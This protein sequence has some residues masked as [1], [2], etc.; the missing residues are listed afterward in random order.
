[1]LVAAT[2]TGC[3]DEAPTAGGGG[4]GAGGGG[5]MPCEP[6][7]A[8]ID[9]EC[10]AAGIPPE[11]CGAGF[12]PTAERG[13]RPVLPDEPCPKGLMAVPGETTCRPV[14]P[15]GTGPW[16]TI[17][18]EPDTQYVDGAYAGGDSDGTAD[19]PWTTIQ[20][21]VDAALPGAIVAVAAGSYEEWVDVT[22]GQV[23]LWGRC[24]ELVE[25]V[26]PPDLPS[27]SVMAGADGAE[28]RDL[29]VRGGGFGVGS[30]GA[31]DV[32]LDR[33][34]VHDVAGRGI[35]VAKFL[36]PSRVAIRRSLIEANRAQGVFAEGAEV[37]MEGVVIRDTEPDPNF[38]VGRGIYLTDHPDTS[39]PSRA[40]VTGSVVE[41]NLVAGLYVSGSELT[42]RSTAVRNT[43]P[44]DSGVGG[45]GIYAVSN[46]FTGL[47]SVLHVETS[48]VA[49]NHYG[50]VVAEGADATILTTVVRDTLPL[51]NGRWGWGI[52]L[53]AEPDTGER[54][55]ATVQATLVDGNHEVGL[56]V[57]GAT[58]ELER[59]IVEDTAP[60]RNDIAGRGVAIQIDL[61]TGELSQAQVRSS[62]IQRNHDIG[63]L[64]ADSD[65]V[66]EASVVSES[67]AR[68]SDG[69]FGDGIVAASLSVRSKAV[70]THS[71]VEQ[72]AR[73]GVV[74]F[75]SDFS[76]G[77]TEIR[78]APVALD[79][80]EYQGWSFAFIDLGGNDCSCADAGATC[81]VLS[82][83]LAPPEPLDG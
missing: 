10:L 74:S 4:A 82:D 57:G 83:G 12:Q 32:L 73:A 63:L 2:L 19:K 51:A 58:V 77:W 25:I 75:G 46:P 52:V 24:P 56:D 40:T 62:I 71:L 36:G 14:A 17:P 54:T 30:S 42:V 34:W 20:A 55:V 5:T 9:G 15:C 64:V 70:V 45:T 67:M 18:V 31:L 7:E 23:R 50:G 47:R 1:M 53:R 76:L 11:A 49:D 13:C 37:A 35:E 6:G 27:V 3:G 69:L 68:V 8:W 79:G 61:L 44:H 39:Q 38:G 78:C 48:V 80:E 33:L 29:A 28:V 21:G 81:K 41:R 59:L 60:G 66:I 26:G 22:T 65:A 43:Q 72:S 16:G